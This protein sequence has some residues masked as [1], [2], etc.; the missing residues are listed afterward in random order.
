MAESSE[1]SSSSSNLALLRQLGRGALLW[2]TTTSSTKQAAAGAGANPSSLYTSATLLAVAE[3]AV[4][5]RVEGEDGAQT[6][7][8]ARVKPANPDILAASPDLAQ[9]SYLNEPSVVHNLNE[10]YDKGNI[11]TRAGPVLVA[12][13]PF[14]RLPELYG[15][16][17]MTAFANGQASSSEPHIFA[18]AHR[19]FKS[20]AEDGAAQSVVISG[21]S[22]AGKTESTKHAMQYLAM[23]AG[24]TSEAGEMEVDDVEAQVLDINPVLE[25]FGNAKT[26]RNNNSSRF[27]K[28]IRI[29]FAR[30]AAGSTISPSIVGAGL[31]TYLL[32]K[33]RVASQSEG[34]R[35]YHVFYQLCAGASEAERKRLRLR[36]SD[37]FKS[38]SGGN[39]HTIA[40][41][42][43]AAM[44]GT[45]CKAM[46]CVG[47]SETETSAAMDVVASIL[48]L[49]EVQFS[50]GDEAQ[51][52]DGVD[53]TLANAAALL[54]CD[55]AALAKALA[56]R[57]ISV[58][59]E[60]IEQ[61]LTEAQ[62]ADTRDA[63]SKTLYAS[64]FTWMCNRI[65]ERLA[66]SEERV[67]RGVS[68]AGGIAD[69]NILDIYGF[70]SFDKNSMEQLLIN[71]ANEKLQGQ[72]NTH[73]F[74][75]EQ[76]EYESEG[77]DWTRIEW[78][79]NQPCL[80]LIESRKPAGLLA[81]LDEECLMP[82]TTDVSLCEKYASQ[83]SANP[84][85][86]KNKR[87]PTGFEVKHFAGDVM[88]DTTGWLEKNRDAISADVK[89]VLTE[90]NHALVP[91]LGALMSSGVDPSARRGSSKS[92]DTVGS[93]FRSQL[94]D[95]I[96]LLDGTSL[97]FVRCIKPNPRQAPDDFDASLVLNQLRCCGVLEV[98]RISSAGYPTRYEYQGFLGRYMFLLPP[99]VQRKAS[100]G[101]AASATR[102]VLRH[103]GVKSESFQCG[104]T[105]VFLRAGSLGA[106]E[107]LRRR[108][109]GAV[110]TCQACARGAIARRKY[111]KQRAA[112]TRMQSIARGY[113]ARIYVQELRMKHH[114][115]T[116]IQCYT[117]GMFARTAFN[118]DYLCVIDAQMAI[119]R[120]LFAHRVRKRAALREQMEREAMELAMQEQKVERDV[121][122]FRDNALYE[123]QY[124]E[125]EAVQI[126]HHHQQ[127][128]VPA[129]A[130]AAAIA[131]ATPGST[132]A[133]S[134][135]P[136]WQVAKAPA[137][138][139]LVSAHVPAPPAVSPAAAADPAVVHMIAEREQLHRHI[140][141]LTEQLRHESALREEYAFRLEESEEQWAAQLGAL[142]ESLATARRALGGEEVDIRGN[143][144]PTFSGDSADS[145]VGLGHYHTNGGAKM[146][147]KLPAG[148]SAVNS[149]QAEFERR[150]AVLDDG[151]MFISEVKEAAGNGDWFADL[152]PE[153]ELAN[154]KQ[155]FQGW[156]R[157]FK[158]RLADTAMVLKKM[159]KQK[160]MARRQDAA[161]EGAMGAA[162]KQVEAGNGGA[163]A[164]AARPASAGLF[165]GV[166]GRRSKQ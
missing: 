84:H 7:P 54:G 74:K 5:V 130:G 23:L 121:P 124:V 159:S 104:R 136:D 14:K 155:R 66:E 164:A 58:R 154:L 96:K 114:A 69:V 77:I 68:C 65:N 27:G 91:A 20:M 137:P 99:E 37:G 122:V 103:F 59:S 107:D 12:V 81:L 138:T 1:S 131:A 48:W 148:L 76:A 89:S 78:V 106:L 126:H 38:I 28:L 75:L 73:L 36:A 102:V 100:A 34:E 72:F 41:V 149:L 118:E 135:N 15:T 50:G 105:K 11:Y 156:K 110:I 143:G 133:P 60:V 117:R 162:M 16:E 56:V 55:A 109:V 157:E 29:H 94:A 127:Q 79:D 98:V 146:T 22:G 21:E 10:R 80:D 67:K 26:L 112:V 70:E 40:G 6:I 125:V 19:A 141:V 2:V 33:S 82:K 18:T 123:E 90:A 120:W 116:M 88:Y 46:S 52:S 25:A 85:F 152:D 166:F 32:E 145:A 3:D 147:A 153:R 83:C 39:C 165:G 51:V 132:A 163:A 115:A 108:T 92:V 8:V 4:K 57:S 9:L 160:K 42:D 64:L 62:A 144:S 71:L 30:P 128:P 113:A 97:H 95:L 139:P 151:T 111:L 49:G 87:M 101:D 150:S 63:L 134:I 44:Y 47:L 93:R 24:S 161:F 119:R 43:D 31:S 129:T 140:T 158:L 13:N 17:A 53:G 45:L 61:S 35:S 86:R 142:R